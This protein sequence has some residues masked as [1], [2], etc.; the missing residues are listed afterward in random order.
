MR[1]T[2]EFEAQAKSL[3]LNRGYTVLQT[4]QHLVKSGC[5]TEVAQVVIRDTMALA[6]AFHLARRN[7]NEPEILARQ[8]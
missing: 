3:L 7:P 4:F 8:S 1:S 2:A 6:Y 5:P